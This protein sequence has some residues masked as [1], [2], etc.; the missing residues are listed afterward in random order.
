MKKVN[1][2]L[3]ALILFGLMTGC[4]SNNTNTSATDETQTDVNIPAG[5]TMT[6]QAK[7][8][9][10]ISLRGLQSAVIDWGDDS[11]EETVLVEAY[12]KHYKHNY[13]QPAEYTIHITGEG[14]KYFS[15]FGLEIINLNINIPTLIY[16][17]CNSSKITTLNLSKI[18]NLEE[19]HCSSNQLTALD[20]SKNTNLKELHCEFNQITTLDISKNTALEKLICSGNKLTTLDV[21]KNTALQVLYC[22]SN[23]LTSLDVSKNKM[24]EHLA[25]GYQPLKSLDLSAN[26]MLKY[27]SCGKTQLTSLDLSKNT[28][29][30]GIDYNENQLSAEA[31]N[32]LYRT[33]H[34]NNG[35][36]YSEKYIH[37]FDNPGTNASDATIA[38][39]KGWAVNVYEGD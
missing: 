7:G 13:A 22:Y 23:Q 24:L 6:F 34:S 36:D 19:L 39:K 17:D 8:E 5:I 27:L 10:Q 28:Q 29:L 33:L 12:Y 35:G 9:V 30:I 11:S 38:E 32:A 2:I 3:A 31:L 4:G 18:T 25:C 26:T 20:V 1:V 14:I 37:T 21:S 15:F 16:L